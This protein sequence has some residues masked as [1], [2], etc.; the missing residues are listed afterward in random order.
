[1]P[2]EQANINLYL[3]FL[4]AMNAPNYDELDNVFFESFI[5]HHPGFHLN[6]LAEYKKALESAHE[7]LN[8]QAALDEIL[9]VDDKVITRVTLSGK[10]V[11]TFFGLTPTYKEVTWTTTEIWRVENGK[12]AERWAQDDLLG[13]LKQLGAVLPN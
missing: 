8:I 12:M 1:M 7:S 6:G 11:G 2:Q 13:L 3:R 10:H 9:A 5:D 4:G